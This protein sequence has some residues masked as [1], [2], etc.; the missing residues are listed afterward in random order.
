MKRLI[1]CASLA[2]VGIVSLQAQAVD[3]SGRPW[4][5]S[6]KLRGFYDDNWA[7]SPDSGGP[8]RQSSWG[9]NFAP[10]VGYVLFRDRTT[11]KANY[12]FDMRW[13]EART[14]NDIDYTHRGELGLTHAFSERYRLDLNDSIVYSSEPGVIEPNGQAAS[15]VRTDGNAWRNYGGAGFTAGLTES[16]G[17]RLGY[18]NTLYDYEEAGFP[19]SRSALLDRMEH[20][21]TADLRW[22]FQPT[23]VGMA[24]YQYGYWGYTSSDQLYA[25]SPGQPPAPTGDAR[26]QESHYGFLGADYTAQPG[27][28]AQIRAG[29]NYARYPNTD[30]DSILAPFV[31]FA[32]SYE[33]MK[34]SRVALGVKHDLRPTDVAIVSQTNG[35]ITTSQEATTVYGYVAHR[36]TEKL[37]GTVRGSWQGGTY[38]GGQYDGY[39]DDFFTA[40]VNL[41]YDLTHYLTA[42]AGYAY[43]IL[44][45]NIP[46][47]PYD[48]NRFYFGVRATY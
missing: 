23:I 41:A 27:L 46:A 9:I 29:V 44:E 40:D 12:D 34:G 22:T 10:G 25:T 15:F 8:P 32:V 18:S 45:S 38:Q 37:M 3:G 13:Y 35:S 28:T 2:A 16:L 21:I 11:L 19:G 33:Y 17:T 6:A 7:T 36:I 43:D 20:L 4:S 5:V 24:G 1:T 14:D 39:T 47:R 26:N 48:R 42:E 31:D 30:A